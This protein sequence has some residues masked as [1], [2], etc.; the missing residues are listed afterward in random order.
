M[1]FLH[2]RGEPSSSLPILG[3][4][5][6]RRELP[7]VETPVFRSCPRSTNGVR[8][9]QELGILPRLAGPQEREAA[10]LVFETGVFPPFPRM[11]TQGRQL[12]LPRAVRF[13]Q[14]F[15]LKPAEGLPDCLAAKMKVILQSGYAPVTFQ[16][17]DLKYQGGEA[18]QR[19]GPAVPDKG[20]D[21]VEKEMADPQGSGPGGGQLLPPAGKH[22]MG[23][24][25]QRPHSR[26][27][28]LPS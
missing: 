17:Q 4:G 3:L 15:P 11:P 28:V 5:E 16:I 20:I 9:I 2:V 21:A 12:P 26:H 25:S 8:Y 10:T 14:P 13:D 6:A 7:N 24:E 1:D 22:T 23:R 19:A 27:K 18:V